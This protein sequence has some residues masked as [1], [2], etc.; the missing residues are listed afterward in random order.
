MPPA[1]SHRRSRTAFSLI[2]LVIGV[3]IIGILAAVA[4]PRFVDAL[5]YYRA[6]GAA[7]RIKADLNFARKQAKASG[8]NVTVTFSVATNAY[9]FT[10]V[11]D[12]DHPSESYAVNLS[13]SDDSTTLVSADF[14]AETSLTFDRYGRPQAGS[15]LA[16][17]VAGTIVVASGGQQRTV[18]VNPTTGKAGMP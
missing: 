11:A 4:T 12:L 1:A 17:L 6:E 13:E 9:Q 10:G 18:V 3:L 7:R 5:A 15:P 8:R 2:E 14:D 16:P